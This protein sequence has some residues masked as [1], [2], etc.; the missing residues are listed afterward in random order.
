[1][2]ETHT[3]SP[4]D[5]TVVIPTFNERECIGDLV[6][7]VFAAFAGTNRAVE[8]VIVDDNS[9]D[10]TGALADELASRLRVTVV[11]RTQKLGLG[12]AVADGFQHATAG[13]IAVMDA[14]FSHPP[15]LLPSLVATFVANNADI[16]VAS[17]YVPG[18]ATRNWPWHRRVY[19]ALACLLAKPLS[20]VKDPVSGFFL[21][22]RGLAQG[23]SIKAPGFKICLELLVR[24]AP[25]RVVEAPFCFNDREGGKSKMN[26]REAARFLTQFRKLYALH[27]SRRG[28]RTP[29]Y[30][31][32]TQHELDASARPN[33]PV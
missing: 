29:A 18:G 22:R 10:G 17:R 16:L 28:G 5:V 7:A 1:M 4:A 15:A 11:H 2:M 14:D 21:I 25:T 19:S 23:T 13:I 27:L 32:V 8:V 20:P 30:V 12:A 3:Q 24:A 6:T 33:A 31:C 26:F 9:P